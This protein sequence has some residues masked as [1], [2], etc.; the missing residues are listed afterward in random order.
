MRGLIMHTIQP[1]GT[2]QLSTNNKL[3]LQ[4]IRIRDPYVITD[5][6]SNSYYLFGTTDSEPWFGKGEGFLVYQSKDLIGWTELG[7][8]FIPGQ[9]FWGE[10]NFW[11]PEIHRYQNGFYMLASFYAEKKCRGVQILKSDHIEGPYIPIVDRAVT[12][13]DWECLDGTL[14]IDEEETPWLIFSHEWTQIEDGAICCAKLSKDLTAMITEP[15]VLFHASEAPWSV[16]D[17]GG[18]IKKEGRNYVT[19]GPFLFKTPGGELKMLWSS[20]SKTGYSIGV[21]SSRSG[22]ITGP[23]V[24]AKE[25]FYKKD[26]GHGMLFRTLEGALRLAIHTPN[27]SPEERAVFLAVDEDGEFGLKCT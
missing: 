18:V 14:F 12:P 5:R 24:Q 26:G 25:P 21:A 11:A 1:C 3:E 20:F 10:K 15:V 27:E 9:N 16:P 8:A 22:R 7:Y 2:Q 13:S 4:D 17:T 23:W 19:D 6:N